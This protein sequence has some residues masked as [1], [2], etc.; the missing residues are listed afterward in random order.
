MGFW[1]AVLCALAVSAASIDSSLAGQ[2]DDPY[3]AFGDGLAQLA[4]QQAARGLFS[5]AVCV[6]REGQVVSSAAFGE[7][8]KRFGIP[9]TGDTRFNL[10]SWNKFMTAIAVCQLVEQDKLGF[11]QRVGEILPSYPSAE[12]RDRVTVHHLLTHT[13]GTGDHFTPE[14]LESSRL[15]YRSFRDYVHLIADNGVAFEPGSRFEYSNAGYFILG[16]IIEEVSGQTYYDYV[17]EH[18]TQPAGALDTE[19]YDA[20]MPV[21]GVA[22]GYI[23]AEH[24][25][26]EHELADLPRL[27][28]EEAGAVRWRSNVHMM[29]VK[30][31]PAGGGYSTVADLTLIAEAFMSDELV[32]SKTRELMTT[33]HIVMPDLPGMHYGYGTM[34]INTPSGRT[35]FGHT[36]D[37]PGVQCVF[38]I[39]PDSESDGYTSIT[40]LSNYAGSANPLLMHSIEHLP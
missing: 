13:G 8:S 17:R 18:I 38:A 39:A 27:V 6:S 30:G 24:Y 33:R 37:F 3:E 22:E 23:P 20:D 34:I 5:G 12:V 25:D 9:N 10:G 19:F 7:A 32:S 16:L 2:P 11:D 21:P 35:L 40:I 36:G 15:Q 29:P 26:S 31:G 1:K 14:F 4:E 28:D